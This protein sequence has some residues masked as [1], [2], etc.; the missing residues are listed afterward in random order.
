M[1]VHGPLIATLM[2]DLCRRSRPDGEVKE[3]SFRALA[4]LFVDHSMMLGAAPAEEGPRTAVWAA[5]D[6]AELAS[7]GEVTFA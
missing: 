2:V 5:N 3:F 4:P 6:K 1:V 7:Q